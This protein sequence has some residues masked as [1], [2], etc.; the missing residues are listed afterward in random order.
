MRISDWSSDVCSS[1]ST[2]AA[3]LPD[4][5]TYTVALRRNLGKR[6]PPLGGG[7]QENGGAGDKQAAQEIACQFKLL[8]NHP[9]LA[10]VSSNAGK[11]TDIR[12]E[13]HNVRKEGV[14]R[15]RSRWLPKSDK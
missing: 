8:R 15:C 6:G 14:L 1:D 9:S 13:E 4:Q 5:L 10:L 12:Q 2:I 7:Q 11:H 3:A